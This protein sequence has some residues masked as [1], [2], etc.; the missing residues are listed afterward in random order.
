ML[1]EGIAAFFAAYAFG[2]LFNIKGKYLVISG[3]GG[4]FGWFLYKICLH[5]GALEA[6]SLFVAS[7]GFS[8]YCETCARIYKTPST[9]LSVCCLIPLVPGYGVYNTLYYF[10]TNDYMNALSYG[11][12]TISNACS[13][14]LGVILV[15]TLYRNH[16]LNK[17]KKYK[18]YVE[19]IK[20]ILKVI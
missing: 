9:I 14:A 10:L 20:K 2:I 1:I 5:T 12:S 11:V 17:L 4:G 8:I 19:I 6:T 15:S 3:V 7:V 13:L 16:S 18:I